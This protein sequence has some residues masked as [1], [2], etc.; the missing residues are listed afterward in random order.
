MNGTPALP[1]EQST[2]S[3]VLAPVK[4]RKHSAIGTGSFGFTTCFPLQQSCT[5]PRES[6]HSW[7]V[8]LHPLF[9]KT[10]IAAASGTAQIVAAQLQ[11]RQWRWYFFLVLINASTSALSSGVTVGDLALML[12]LD[13]ELGLKFCV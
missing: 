4:L 9:P 6:E 3:C 12:A 7:S 13:L 8:C 5:L 1:G 11:T 10:F 2:T